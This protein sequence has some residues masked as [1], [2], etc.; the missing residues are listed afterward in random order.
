MRGE[1]EAC[2]P[3]KFL[4]PRTSRVKLQVDMVVV[5]ITRKLVKLQKENPAGCAGESKR[6]KGNQKKRKGR[7]KDNRQ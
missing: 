4:I 2:G 1:I 7:F 3:S 6:S 5:E